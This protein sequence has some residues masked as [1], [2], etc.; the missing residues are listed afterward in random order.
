MRKPTISEIENYLAE[1][2]P[3]NLGG[4]NL[5]LTGEHN[6]LVYR[7]KKGESVFAIRMI[8]PE[9]YRAGEWISMAEEYA[10]L[11]ALAHTN[12]APWAYYLGEDFQPPILIQEFIE[13]TCFNDL[14]P[15]SVAHLVDVARAIAE[16]NS[17]SL[18]PETL[19]FLKKYTEESFRWRVVVWQVRLL[20]AIRRTLQ[21]DVL[22]WAVRILPI[23]IQAG[24]VL[25]RFK[26]LFSN[27]P[28][29][30]H[31]DGAHTGNTYWRNEKTMFLD[32][33]RVSYRSD[34]TF[35]LVRF[36]TS[37]DSEKGTV[38]PSTFETLAETYQRY[39]PVSNFAAMARVRLLERQVSDLVWVLLDYARRGDKRTVVEGTSIISRFEAV[40]EL[41]STF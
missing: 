32:W 29:V 25:N 1:R 26:K 9:S 8:N 19:P 6:H 15:L 36:M 13:G 18:S 4:A 24:F 39:R 34:P 12:L 22:A 33:Q 7:A 28:F 30:F 23:A 21:K 37:V 35:T 27:Q 14:K 11:R 3:L 10:L 2:N 40:H 38:S 41:L 31:F 17:Q 20:D 16:L 5:T